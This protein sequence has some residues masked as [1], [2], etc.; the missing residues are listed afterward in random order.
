MKKFNWGTGIVIA[1]IAFIGF[2]LYFVISMT[3]DKN[4]NH[5]LVT[6]GYYQKELKYQDQIDATKN[7]QQLTNKLEIHK[8][9]KGLMIFFPKDFDSKKITGKVSLYRPSNKQLDFEM[10]ILISEKSLLVPEN[11]LVDGRWDIIVEWSYNNIK[12]F[13]K[14]DLKY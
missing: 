14:E 11:R 6:D 1:F 8:T 13:H 7:S 9:E 4:F 10:P 5:D 3:V 2:I 12:Y